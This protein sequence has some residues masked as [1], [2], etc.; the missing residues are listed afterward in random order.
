[1]LQVSSELIRSRRSVRTFDDR[2]LRADHLDQIREFMEEIPNPYGI[3]VEFRLLDAQQYGLS[4][5]VLNHAETYVAAKVRRVPHAEEAYGYS[6]E[7]L[8]LFAESLGIGTVWIG[9][10]MNRP[11]FETAMELKPDEMMPCVSP[12]GYAAKKMSL[13][14]TMMRKGVR[15]DWREDGGSMFFDG[16][17]DAPLTEEKAGALREALEA[18]RWAPSAVNK[19]PWRVVVA[20]D[21]VHF[22]EKKTKGY[23]SDA[24][25]DLQKIDVGIALCHFDLMCR[26]AGRAPVF[27]IDDP[28]LR[29]EEDTEYIATYDLH[30]QQ[31]GERT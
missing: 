8:V 18:V 10:T 15:A 26:A 28:G 7:T 2:A 25:G 24:T 6:F 17:F 27:V 30:K 5:P 21:K 19:Q 1:M 14:E 22:Y 12:L 4:S 31:E 11:A 16:S 23:V 29:T 9:G 20:G 3:P 13:R